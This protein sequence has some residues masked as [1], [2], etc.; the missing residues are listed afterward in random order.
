[1]FQQFNVWSRVSNLALGLSL[2]V[3]ELNPFDSSPNGGFEFIARRCACNA[4]FQRLAT[5]V[6]LPILITATAGVHRSN[7]KG[8]CEPLFR[9]I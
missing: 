9:Y 5:S 7:P 8:H 1:M 3:A 4:I 2:P 6:T